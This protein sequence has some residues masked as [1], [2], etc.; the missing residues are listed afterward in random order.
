MRMMFGQRWQYG[1]SSAANKTFADA[2]PCL[3]AESHQALLMLG[4]LVPL[5]R[6]LPN[7]ARAKKEANE[8]VGYIRIFFRQMIG[9]QINKRDPVENDDFINA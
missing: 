7:V 2:M 5:F 8:A 1:D 9:K 6:Y 4:D 3:H